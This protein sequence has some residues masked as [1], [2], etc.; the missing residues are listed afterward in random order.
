MIRRP[1][2]STLFPYTTLFRSLGSEPAPPGTGRVIDCPYAPL[3]LEPG[4]DPAVPSQVRDAWQMWTPNKALGMTG[5][6]AAYAIAPE[7]V[8]HDEIDALRALSPSWP[9]GA[10]GEAMLTAWT[11]IGRAHV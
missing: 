8:P 9:V 4:M 3:R 11:E 2:R 7:A 10:H 1:P 5:V 6:R